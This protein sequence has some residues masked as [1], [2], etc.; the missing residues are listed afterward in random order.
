MWCRLINFTKNTTNH[1][2]SDDLLRLRM[3]N[4]KTCMQLYLSIRLSRNSRRYRSSQRVTD[5]ERCRRLSPFLDVSC[6]LQTT[7][8]P[9]AVFLRRRAPPIE[10]SSFRQGEPRK[11]GNRHRF[12]FRRERRET[13]QHSNKWKKMKWWERVFSFPSRIA[14][15]GKKGRCFHA[16]N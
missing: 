8:R 3:K 13:K 5:R 6:R 14:T 15:P 7:T 1:S 12:V 10:P 11:G 2:K 9:T 16:P 4:L